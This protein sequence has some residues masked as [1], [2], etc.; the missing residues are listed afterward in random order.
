MTG[1]A[2][3]ALPALWTDHALEVD[4]SFDQGLTLQ[5]A[6]ATESKRVDGAYTAQSR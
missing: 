1:Y 6:I 4:P 2:H 3:L 5:T